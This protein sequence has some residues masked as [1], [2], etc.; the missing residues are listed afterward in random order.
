MIILLSLLSK[1]VKLILSKSFFSSEKSLNKPRASINKIFSLIVIFFFIDL[2][3]AYFMV[4]LSV[5]L[6]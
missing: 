1:V 4:K 3:T 5:I 2:T 6:T